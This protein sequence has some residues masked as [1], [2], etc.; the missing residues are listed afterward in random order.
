MTKVA[1]KDLNEGDIVKLTVSANIVSVTQDGAAFGEI[2]D[3]KDIKGVKF[4]INAGPLKGTNGF[5]T[6]E[7][8]DKLT[9]TKRAR[10][11]FKQ[12]IADLVKGK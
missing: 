1:I 8:S 10:R 6:A 5:A 7:A 11:T 3:M 9:V 12:I 2:H 4:M